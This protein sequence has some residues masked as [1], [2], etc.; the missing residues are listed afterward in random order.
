MTKTRFTW[1]IS[2]CLAG[3]SLAAHAADSLYVRPI[4]DL[5]LRNVPPAPP[6]TPPST[7]WNV[8]V[9]GGLSLAPRYSGAAHDRL[10]FIPLLEATDGHFFASMLRGA[11]YNFS[12]TRGLAY[13]LRLAVGRARREDADPHLQGMGNIPYSIEGGAFLNQRFGLWYLSGDVSAG[14]HGAHAA[15]GGGMALPLSIR[16]HIRLGVNLEWSGRR[17]NQTYF[18]VT[19]AQSAASGYVLAPYDAGGG[20]TDYALTANWAHSYSRQWFSTLGISFKQLT[21]NAR[22]SPLTQSASQ[23]SANFIVGYR[24]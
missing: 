21:G 20:L 5:P 12:D 1:L 22:R 9:G 24:F 2:A 6:P 11:G 19:A 8:T 14:K 18:G 7:V 17:Y 13:G 16:D 3:A 15:L 23:P 10:R 4:P